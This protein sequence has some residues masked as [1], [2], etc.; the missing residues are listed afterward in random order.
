MNTPK[1][2]AVIGAGS[3]GSQAMWRLAARGADVVGY[4]RYAPGHD[5]GAAG[6]D[7][8][9]YRSGN[10]WDAAYIPLLRL[11]DR[12]WDQLHHETGRVL[13]SRNG[14]L[15]MGETAS[16]SMQVL[17]SSIAD[18]DLDHELLDREDLARRY[19]QHVFPKDTQPC[20]TGPAAPSGPRRRSRPP[21]G[22]PSS[23]APGCTATPRSGRWYPRRAAAW[24]S[25]PITAATM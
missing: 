12:M 21:P 20:S 11:A 10:L 3:M 2:I 19:P 1:R 22:G 24:T 8:R 13:R 6:G 18:H 7:T 9:I 15:V 16:A 5:R 23:W 17:L 14:C 4:D 25:S